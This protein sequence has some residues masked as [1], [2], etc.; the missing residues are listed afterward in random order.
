M[1]TFIGIK[2][3]RR[4]LT[5]VAKATEKGQQFIV[6]RRSKPAF[7]VVPYPKQEETLDLPGWKTMVDFTEGGKKSGVSADELIE[8]IKRVIQADGQAKKAPQKAK[9]KRPT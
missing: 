9:Q 1:S 8:F 5:Q 7:M 3:F 4:S 6:M 2:D